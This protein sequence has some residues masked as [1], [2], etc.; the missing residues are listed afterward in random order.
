MPGP[1]TKRTKAKGAAIPPRLGWRLPVAVG[2]FLTA[3]ACPVVGTAI[4]ASD[5]SGTLKPAAGLLFFPIP[6]IFDAPRSRSGQ[7]RPG[8]AEAKLFGALRRAAPPDRVGPTRH[9]IGL[10]MFVLPLLMGWLGPY[11]VGRIPPPASSPRLL[12]AGG[13]LMS[14]ASFFILGGDFW[15]KVGALRPPCARRVP[16]EGRP[17]PTPV[18]SLTR[19]FAAALVLLKGKP[20]DLPS[21]SG[22]SQPGSLPTSPCCRG[23]WVTARGHNG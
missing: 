21:R 14:L 19:A 7:A 6:E 9:R 16:G 18:T 10:V 5:A 4:L 17:M 20:L 22:R 2:L 3:I 8:V 11:M 13:D 15:D 23:A 1:A 12:H